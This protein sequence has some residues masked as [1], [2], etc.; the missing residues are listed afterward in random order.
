MTTNLSYFHLGTD[1]P[2]LSN[3]MYYVSFY[4]GRFLYTVR[5]LNINYSANIRTQ[6]SPMSAGTTAY[7]EMVMLPFRFTGED[8]TQFLPVVTLRKEILNPLIIVP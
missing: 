8:A 5:A 4:R 1:Q 6:R 7:E 2:N 3:A